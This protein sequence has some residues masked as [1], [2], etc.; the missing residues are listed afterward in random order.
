MPAE[1]ANGTKKKAIMAAVERLIEAERWSNV[2]TDRIAAEAGVGKGTIYRYFTDKDDLLFEVASGGFDELCELLRRPMPDGDGFEPRLI[3]AARRISDFFQGRRNLIR[4]MQAQDNLNFWKN[5]AFK[6]RWCERRNRLID[7]VAEL[8]ERGRTEGLVRGD[9]NCRALA[10]YLLG[11]MRTRARDLQEYDA[12]SSSV[13]AVVDLFCRGATPT[14]T[15][16]SNR[17]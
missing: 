13:E 8:L 10:S 11:M 2:T 5:P 16:E 14:G 9:I 4:M 17:G 1:Q 7:T 15:L 12:Q 6:Q 3:E